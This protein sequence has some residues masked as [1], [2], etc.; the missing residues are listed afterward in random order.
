MVVLNQF[1][2]PL[3]LL[4]ERAAYLE[5]SG[6]LLVADLHLGKSATFQAHGIP[7]PNFTTQ[8]TLERL[9]GLCENCQPK[10]LMILG[11][12]FHSRLAFSDGTW[13]S[14]LEFVKMLSTQI[15]IN[16]QLVV[17]NHDRGLIRA[18][19]QSLIDPAVHTLINFTS[20]ALHLDD[21]V[22]SHEPCATPAMLNICGH[23]HPCI[24]LKT[25]LDN[26]R[27]PCFYLDQ[28]QK[29]LVLPSFGEFTGG[30]E[31][32]LEPETIAYA[33]A[34]TQIIPFPGKSKCPPKNPQPKT[35]K[36]K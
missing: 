14:W 2:T 4:P 36:K 22:L 9:Q 1:K 5:H 17:G 30:W 6:T 11:D 31:V 18:L 12:L 34:D 28:P 32:T 16:V 27:L 7:V 24:R 3:Q 13:E 25:R 10:S 15:P 21:L 23:I 19:N 29:L 20:E 8:K 35:N 26:L 33:I